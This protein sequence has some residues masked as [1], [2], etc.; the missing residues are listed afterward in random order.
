M[1]CPICAQTCRPALRAL[2]DDRYGYPGHFD[3]YRCPACGHRALDARFSAEQLGELYSRYYPRSSLQLSDY[4]PH[5]RRRGLAAWLDGDDCAAWR[6]VPPSVRVL[7]IGCGFGEALG[8]HQSRGCS[9]WGVDADDNIRRVGEHF[10]FNVQVGLFDPAC[11]APGFFDVITLD[12]VIEHVQDPLRTLRDIAS[13]LAPGGVVII[14]TPFAGG[15]GARLFGRRWINWHTPYHV[16]FFTPR[17]MQVAAAQAGLQLERSRCRTSSSWLHYQWL[18]LFSY[19]HPGQPSGF[20]THDR[21]WSLLEKVALRLLQLSHQLRI[22]HLLTR[23][24]DALSLGDNRLY[25]L[26]KPR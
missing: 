26:R 23:L 18:H 1:Q 12:Q 3:L 24:A 19:P 2:Y 22:N 25:I 21:R 4:R 15:W 9:V 14:S 6:W 5:R 13:V 17:S 7:D 16:Q 20:W 11:Y 8:Y 10:G